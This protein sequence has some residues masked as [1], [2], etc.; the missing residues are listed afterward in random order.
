MLYEVITLS[1]NA[2]IFNKRAFAALPPA[3]QKVVMDAA[4]LSSLTPG[5]QAAAIRRGQGGTKPKGS[6]NFV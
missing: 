4:G 6:Y 5:T 2:L 1:K 3:E